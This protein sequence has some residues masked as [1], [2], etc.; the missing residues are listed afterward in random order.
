MKHIAKFDIDRSFV[1]RRHIFEED[2]SDKFD[3][4]AKYFLFSIL[5]I[6]LIET[7]TDRT[8]SNVN[9]LFVAVT[10][11]QCLI[12]FSAYIIY[13]KA[14]EKSFFNLSTPLNRQMKKQLLLE[15]ADIQQLEIYRKSNDSI[16]LIEYTNSLNSNWGKS[17]IFI[18]ADNL[19]LF[20]ILREGYRLDFPT[21]TSHI[22]L[23]HN[24]RSLLKK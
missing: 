13:R 1:K 8:Y 19:I 2:W 23:K 22:F 3:R 5:I 18:I 20:T 9:D 24:L 12:L 4:F 7:M 15:F 21:L 11:F 17:M 14:K 6:T 16:I 10:I